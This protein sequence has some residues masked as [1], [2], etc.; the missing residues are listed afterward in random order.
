MKN[1]RKVFT[2]TVSVLSYLFQISY[3]ILYRS[4]VH[5]RS[6]NSF[7]AFLNTKQYPVYKEYRIP[8]SLVPTKMT[9]HIDSKYKFVQAVLLL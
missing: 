7:E 4:I 3:L 2:F 5:I 6:Y 1:T 8:Y 9:I